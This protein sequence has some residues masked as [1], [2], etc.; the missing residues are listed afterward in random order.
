MGVSAEQVLHRLW[1]MLGPLVQSA[2]QWSIMS[3]M[4]Q[5]LVE[6]WG[7]EVQGRGVGES[8]QVQAFD[9]QW[10]STSALGA[11]GEDPSAPQQVWRVCPFT[12]DAAHLEYGDDAAEVLE[13]SS[14]FKSELTGCCVKESFCT[15]ER[16]P[17][18]HGHQHSSTEDW[19]TRRQS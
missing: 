8:H 9:L 3:Q 6:R 14:R 12:A 19:K 11:E 15:V 18:G 13:C 5:Q 10:R 16:A 17:Q 4:L 2:T 7:G 1:G